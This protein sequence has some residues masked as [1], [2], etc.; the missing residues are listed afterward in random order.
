ME[1]EAIVG[2]FS[3]HVCIVERWRRDT[4]GISLY[5]QESEIRRAPSGQVVREPTS[6]LQ[7][8]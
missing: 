5:R 8:Q 7:L 3:E 1:G 4:G 6:E 2:N